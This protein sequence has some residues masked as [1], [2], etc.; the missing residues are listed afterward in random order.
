MTKQLKKFSKF[1]PGHKPNPQT[2]K[3]PKNG[4]KVSKTRS[5]ENLLKTEKSEA[6][7]S[8]EIIKKVEKISSIQQTDG[9]L[10]NTISFKKIYKTILDFFNF[11]LTL[12]KNNQNEEDIRI[13]SSL[14]SFFKKNLGAGRIID[15]RIKEVLISSFKHKANKKIQFFLRFLGLL[16]KNSDYLLT[17]EKF[18][19][20]ALKF[21]NSTQ[22]GF[23]LPVNL[24]AGEQLVPYTRIIDFLEEKMRKR[25][26]GRTWG[27]LSKKLRDMAVKDFRYEIGR[28]HV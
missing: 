7:L 20:S 14:Y 1:T 8:K 3:I 5:K 16:D 15:K 6:N 9:N 26:D 25:V 11:K 27:D 10:K 12:I 18:Y 2:L 22:K 13:K 21:V 28:A 23:D 4:K 19:I 24:D 17:E